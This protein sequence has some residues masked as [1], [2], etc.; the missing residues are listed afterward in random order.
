[1][2]RKGSM[3][4]KGGGLVLAMSAAAALIGIGGV[5]Q[6]DLFGIANDSAFG[7][8]VLETVD[9]TTHTVVGSFVPDGA[10]I[11][12]SNGRGVQLFIGSNIVYY[13][14]L[15]GNGFGPTDVIRAAPWNN[16]A[17]GA[18]VFSFA[19]P[20]PGTGVAVLAAS[21]GLLYILTGYPNGPEVVQAFTGSGVPVG[22]TVTL[23]TLAGGLLSDSDGFTILPNGNWLINDGDAVNSYNQYNPVTGNE[24]AGTTV[25]GHTTG[26]ALCGSSTGVDNNGTSLFF[27]CNLNNMVEDTFAGVFIANNNFDRGG[28]EDLSNDAGQVINPPSGAPEPASLSV[29]GA[30]LI[31]LGWLRRRQRSA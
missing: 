10:K 7:N 3:L 9:L 8:G 15:T 14:E 22:S 16:G 20:V 12:S 4:G 11:G 17:G 6:A 21:G 18:D 1:M 27:D 19:N 29:L 31:G 23:H 24:I 2:D 28:F 30:A 25:Q 5:A 13:T 26:G